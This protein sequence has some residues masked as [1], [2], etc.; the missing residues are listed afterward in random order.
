MA[1]CVVSPIM[2]RKTFLMAITGLMALAFVGFSSA[3]TTNRSAPSAAA[4]P[5]PLPSWR[6]G[7]AKQRIVEFV[8]TVTTTGS[9]AFVPAAQRI[10]AFDNDGTLWNEQPTWVQ[11]AFELDRVAALAPQHPE[12]K[13][14]LLFKAA[15]E[16]DLK[17]LSAMGLSGALE[18][19]IAAQAGL[20]IE[21]YEREVNDWLATARH[22]RFRRP[23][24]D[25]VYQPM[26]EMLAYLR[27]NGFKTFIV[28]GGSLE[29]MRPWTERVYGVPPEQV[30]GSSFKTEFELRDGRPVI[31]RLPEVD[32]IDDRDGKALGIEK[33]IGCRPIIAFGNSDGDIQMLEWTTAG[34]GARL[35]VYVHHDD[36]ERETA[37]DRT[38]LFGKLDRGLNEAPKRGWLVISMKNDWKR[39]F[40]FE[41]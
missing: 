11:L 12:W 19:G 18:L 23:Y 27:A 13:T 33:F 28:S 14:N 4:A 16:R 25:L 7:A 10:A 17:T 30:V 21:D 36:G 37:Y 22:P 6:E 41:K 2:T 35:A 24:T 3:Q 38:T 34:D 39:V 15:L 5:D 29:F 26:L 20:T 1:C 9:P 40:P 31:T 32:F 8:A